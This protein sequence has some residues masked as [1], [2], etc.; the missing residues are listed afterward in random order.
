M[1]AKCT[2]F[3]GHKLVAGTYQAFVDRLHE[4]LPHPVLRNTVHESV[5]GLLKK[6]LT[7][8][9]LQNVTWRLAGNLDQLFHQQAVPEWNGQKAFEWVPA[10]VCEVQLTR[11]FGKLVNLLT[12]QSLGGTVVPLKIVQTWS[13]KKTNYLAVYRNQSGL[14]FGFGR[15]RINSRGEQQ[16]SGL[17]R[18][19]SQF[20]GMRCFLLIDPARSQTEPIAVEIGHSGASM[21]Y[22]RQLIQG[23][24]R[25][26]TPCLKGLPKA[27]ECFACPYGVDRCVLATHTATYRKGTCPRCSQLGFFDPLEIEHP[28]LCLTCIQEERKL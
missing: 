1:I 22:N 4:N 6:E 12:F 24:D 3:L 16:N 25:S 8:E 7:P 19:L 15:S 20:Y 28:D 27:L 14:G 18:N 2:D 13:I 26:Q 21:A 9:L 10:Q 5:K 17:Y 23:R 11:R